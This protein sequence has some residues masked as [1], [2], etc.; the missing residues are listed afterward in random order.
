MENHIIVIIKVRQL[1]KMVE[2]IEGNLLESKCDIICHQVNCKRAMGRGIAGQIRSIWPI[3]YN[4]Y[5]NFIDYLYINNHIKQ[6]KD[7]LGFINWTEVD[8]YYAPHYVVNFFSQ[9]EY[10]P[11][12]RCHT[13]Y[14]AFTKCCKALKKFITKYNL[15]NSNTIIGFPYKIGCGLAGGDW[16]VVY[17]IIEEEFQD[18]NVKIYKLNVER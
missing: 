10:Y 2:I 12:D 16:N 15:D 18:Y 5:C 8:S 9:D 4:D 14:E 11:R 3:V 17:N 1:N 13:N 7:L 6:S